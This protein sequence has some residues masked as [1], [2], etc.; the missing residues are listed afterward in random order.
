[1]FLTF[2][3]EALSIKKSDIRKYLK[4]GTKREFAIYVFKVSLE[5]VINDIIEKGIEFQF[6]NSGKDKAYM[7]LNR[8]S[9][10]EFI[11]L[12]KR[13]AFKDFD[14]VA[15]DFNAYRVEYRIERRN[16]SVVN[17]PVHLNQAST[18]RIAELTAAN[19]IKVGPIRTYQDYY[20]F[21]LNKFPELTKNDVYRIFRYG[22]NTFRMHMS[23]GGDI[24]IQSG[25][26]ILQTGKIYTN[27]KLMIEYVMKKLRIKTRVMYRRLHYLWDGY[28]YFSLTAEKFNKIKDDFYAGK[29]VDFGTVA[30]MK[31]YDEAIASSFDRAVLFRVKAGEECNRFLNLEHLITDKAELIEVFHGWTWDTLRLSNRQYMTLFPK[32]VSIQKIYDQ[33]YKPYIQWLRA[34]RWQTLRK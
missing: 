2:N 12:R 1:M 26:F 27:W 29:T 19:K 4:D 6:Q 20:E 13:G 25:K 22:F 9:G 24:F 23:Y 15:T 17:I 33:N 10:D 21:A 14:P 3:T 28:T 11:K 5:Q 30:L 8:I 34:R 18:K 16:G 31:C 7:R 32:T